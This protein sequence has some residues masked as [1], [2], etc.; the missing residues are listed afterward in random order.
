MSLRKRLLFA[1]LFA[2]VALAEPGSYTAEFDV[3]NPNTLSRAPAPA[4]AAFPW[5]G[6]WPANKPSR[7]RKAFGRKGELRP[8]SFLPIQFK[9]PKDL[10]IG[11]LLVASRALGELKLLV[12]YIDGLIFVDHTMIGAV[13]VDS[14]ATIETNDNSDFNYP[15]AGTNIGDASFG[16]YLTRGTG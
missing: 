5:Y 8:T 2:I 6:R 14:D 11:K 10:G 3:Q 7:W 16:I 15:P 4:T 12:I 13:G 9:N 1:M